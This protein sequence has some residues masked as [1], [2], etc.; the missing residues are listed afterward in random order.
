VPA[1]VSLSLWLFYLLG[2]TEVMTFFY[3]G[4]PLEGG[5]SSPFMYYQQAGAFI[6]FALCMM[7]M[8]RRHLWAVLRKAFGV[9]RDVDDSAEPIGYALAFWGLVAAMAGMV[10]WYYY[11]KMSIWGAVLLLA[12]EFTVVLVHARMVAQGGLFFTQ[13]SWSP[14]EVL[15]G[16]TGGRAF[17]GPAVVVAHVQHA[18]L[19]YDSREIFSPHVSNAFR[20]SS[21]FRR[22][23]RLLLPVIL[24]T[25]LV[26][27]VASGYST[28]RWV[29]YRDGAL[30]IPNTHSTN[31]YP[32]YMFNKVDTMLSNPTQVPDP[33]YGGLIMG[34]GLMFAL[35]ALR[36]TFYW[37]PIH[38]LGL[39]VASSW[40]AT[41]LYFSFLLGW[42]TKVSILKFAG[43]HVLRSAR[44]FFLGVIVAESAV[45]GVSTFVSLLTGV[46]IGYVFLSG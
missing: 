18:L 43:G 41:Q 39:A 16:L 8:A 29:Y 37:W 33:S 27:M 26:G 3:L 36:T 7:Y 38:P 9:G 19:T 11:F 12:L 20:I 45:I 25:L 34:A 46:R 44:K 5:S 42:L 35:T 31:Y 30:N 17:S 24:V 28:L 10:V 2:A 4:R 14:P 40:C 1:D 15:Y 32:R 21:V 23:R 22:G 6:A 13:Q